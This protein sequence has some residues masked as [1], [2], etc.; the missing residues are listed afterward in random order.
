MENG[1]QKP[2]S[3]NTQK[4][5]RPASTPT[6]PSIPIV[7][8]ESFTGET[9]ETNVDPSAV[10]DQEILNDGEGNDGV[11]ESE[12]TDY[13]LSGT[14]NDS[15]LDS[16][17]SGPKA[18]RASTSILPRFRGG[19]HK[20]EGPESQ[21][22]P[23]EVDKKGMLPLLNVYNVR[24]LGGYEDIDLFTQDILPRLTS[25]VATIISVTKIKQQG[26]SVF[27]YT[28]QICKKTVHGTIEIHLVSKSLKSFYDFHKIVNKHHIPPHLTSII[29][30]ST[31]V[32]TICARTRT[33]TTTKED[34]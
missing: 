12:N 31:S 34:V 18:R 26:N 30:L 17:D 4:A 23:S 15:L 10:R 11:E 22:K 25:T 1:T 6:G 16:D 33:R 20:T 27:M 24:T 29:L 9:K 5:G 7:Q 21:W 2:L 13:Q 14:D 28:I 19:S 3:L 32:K 8:E